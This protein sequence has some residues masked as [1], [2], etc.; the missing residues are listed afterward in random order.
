[1]SLSVL[2]ID[3][4]P[5]AAL[6]IRAGYLAL[7]QVADFFNIHNPSDPQPTDPIAI[8]R[9]EFDAAVDRLAEAGLPVVEDRDQAWRDFA[10]WRVNYDECLLGL[11][12]M[13]DPPT[14]PWTADRPPL[15]AAGRAESRFGR[16]RRR[17]VAV[18]RDDDVEGV[19]G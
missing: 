13:V 10:G 16:L 8:K 18:A 15:G 12:Q 6:A 17:S 4:P 5:Q 1:M 3:R 2:E 19:D 14:A 7:R 9:H 11:A